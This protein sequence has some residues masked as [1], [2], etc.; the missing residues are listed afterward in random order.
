MHGQQNIKRRTDGRT[1]GQTDLKKL[2]FAVGKFAN[3][4]KN[5]CLLLHRD[6]ITR[7]S[8]MNSGYCVCILNAHCGKRRSLTAC[9]HLALH[10]TH[11]TVRPK[12]IIR[13]YITTF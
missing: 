8:V 13:C 10:A 1:D 9:F 2:I 7:A 5:Y 12:L 11:G 3:D 4:P 6:N